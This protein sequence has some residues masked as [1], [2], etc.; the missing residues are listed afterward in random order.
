MSDLWI[1]V[2]LQKYHQILLQYWKDFM[3][4]KD[5]RLKF[6]AFLFN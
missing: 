6:K 3:K 2:R 5:G 4:L 1:Y